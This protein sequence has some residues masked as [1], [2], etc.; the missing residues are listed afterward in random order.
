MKKEI[1]QLVWVLLGVLAFHAAQAQF[2]RTIE[3]G[4]TDAEATTKFR[5]VLRRG[6][7]LYVQA[8]S[9]T[10][11]LGARDK[12]RA[13]IHIVGKNTTGT[14]TEHQGAWQGA[15]I[16]S[17]LTM[18]GQRLML[19]SKSDTF[20]ISNLAW[21]GKGL[22]TAKYHQ[23]YLELTNVVF[24]RKISQAAGRG[25]KFS[26]NL[27]DMRDGFSGKITQCS[28]LGFGAR[29]I[30]LNR[31][32]PNNRWKR[33]AISVARLEIDKCE[34]VPHW[35]DEKGIRALSHDAGN[36]EY[37]VIWNHGGKVISN[38][39]FTDCGIS[40]SKGSNFSITGNTFNMSQG[41]NDVIHLEEYSRNIT[42][43]NNK[44]VL[45]ED[46]SD[47]FLFA[48]AGN[49]G[50]DDITITGNTVEQG[51]GQLKAF[52]SGKNA[53]DI[54]FQSNKVLNPV[55]NA[56]YINFF[57]CGNVVTV[58]SGQPG[59]II[60]ISIEPP[61]SRWLPMGSITYAWG[62]STLGTLVGTF[63]LWKRQAHP[64]KRAINGGLSM[65]VMLIT[66]YKPCGPARTTW[67]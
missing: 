56:R 24:D 47:N 43:S 37:P 6:G 18:R 7:I 35:R 15:H 66:R 5:R 34:F 17:T 57:G 8:G 29:A 9:W 55:A 36:D 54:S 45:S 40:A 31:T 38:S 33:P 32:L 44:A 10:I 42:I 23:P 58:G 4:D 67:R 48:G 1:R 30:A 41:V 22:E 50:V 49:H 14:D 13:N 27:L 63:A 61:V 25:Q 39:V 46:Y 3:T 16:K 21:F 12:A 52:A 65:C 20:K 26:L 19:N 53:K 60:K 28:F 62:T 64:G 59:L 2:T 11:T 51:N